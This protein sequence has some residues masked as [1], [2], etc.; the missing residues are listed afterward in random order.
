MDCRFSQQ[1]FAFQA[2]YE[3]IAGIG[4]RGGQIFG[5]GAPSRASTLINYVGFD[6]CILN[7]V[8][9]IK[10]SKKVGHYI[11]GTDIPIMEEGKLYQ[12][13]PPFVLLLS[14]HIAEELCRNLKRRGYR[15]DFIVPLPQPRII[16]N[17]DVRIN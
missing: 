7:C 11:P 12:D 2:L 14:W 13:Q 4:G 5:V 15:G 1:G 6:S 17:E 8:L 9:E 10:E 3:L 16:R